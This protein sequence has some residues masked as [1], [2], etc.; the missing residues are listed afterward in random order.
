M[1]IQMLILKQIFTTTDIQSNHH[2]F[3]PSKI[4]PSNLSLEKL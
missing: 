2:I 3:V 4:F 1:T